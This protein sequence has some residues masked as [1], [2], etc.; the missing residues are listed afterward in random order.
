MLLKTILSIYFLFLALLFAQISVAQTETINTDR[1]DQSDGVTTVFKN[2]FQIENGITIAKKTVV[3]NLM[4]RY[5]LTKSTE[6]RLLIDYGKELSSTG[7]KPLTFSIKQK[8]LEQNG[9]VPATSFV[10]Y[11]AYEKISGKDFSSNELLYE[12]KFAFENEINHIFSIGY[13]AGTTRKF[14]DYN[15]SFSL[16][17]APLK[18][19]SAYVEYFSTIRKGW[20]EHN[21]DAGIL[22]TPHPKIQFDIAVG[23]SLQK[24]A[25]RMFTT[26][27]IS[28]AF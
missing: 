8:L 17:M 12:L 10:G 5:G 25:K 11:I 13:N 20:D 24:A 21:M 19:L 18:K 16:A 15:F 3:N 26:F 27:G 6:F 22:F 28:Y 7:F 1:P 9:I 23:R 4:L 2:H 14:K